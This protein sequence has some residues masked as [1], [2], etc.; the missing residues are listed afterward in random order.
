MKIVH[1]KFAFGDGIYSSTFF[2]SNKESF[3][4]FH[5]LVGTIFLIVIFFRTMAYTFQT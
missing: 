4:G 2:M 1:A 3:H 5:V